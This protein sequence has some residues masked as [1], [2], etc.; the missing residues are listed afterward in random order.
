M[1]GNYDKFSNSNR[2]SMNIAYYFCLC[3]Y[4]CAIVFSQDIPDSYFPSKY[5]QIFHDY[6]YLWQTNSSFKPYQWKSIYKLSIE[7]SNQLVLKWLHEDLKTYETKRIISSKNA[8][9]KLQCDV[10]FGTLLQYSDGEGSKF[11]EGS[12]T[13]YSY[14][15]FRYNNHFKA[16]L[17]PRITTNQ[18]S[19]PHYTGKPRPNKRAGFDTGETDMAGLGYFSNWVQIWFGRGR[20]NWGAFE[21][22]NVA[23][24]EKSAAYDHG[25][26]QFIFNNLRLRYF[27]G[28]LESLENYNHRYITGRG[29]E[30]NNQQNLVLAAHEV[31]I[32]SGVDRPLD[33]AYFNPIST[34]LEIELNEYDNH[35]GDTNGGNAIWQLAADWMPRNGIRFSGNMLAD[36]IALD[37]IERNA[38]KSHAL[39][40]QGRIALSS[41]VKRFA[42]TAFV[43]YTKVGTYTFRH[44][45][46]SNNFISRNIPL[47][48]EIGSDSDQS[49]VG[50]RI[51]TPLRWITTIRIG[52][53][54]KGERTILKD[55]YEPWDQFIRVSFPSGDVE[56]S[57]FVRWETDWVPR[58]NMRINLQSQI[59]KSN[60]RGN[61]NYMIISLD[62]YLPMQFEI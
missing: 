60:L 8:E 39:A 35:P 41:I 1:L 51:I 31:V 21:L 29:I 13:L 53:Q 27:H 58:R 52:N 4:S 12:T 59:C 3:F 47:G 61:Q 38:G 14:L 45:N 9:N 42:Y 10:L 7:D 30:Y 25:T 57:H 6:G 50:V 34:H 16:W 43:E 11:Q 15:Y 49:I 48:T 33:I 32:Y 40:F 36:E 54:R 56:R 44:G 37:K 55:P 2:H 26:L 18:Y 5:L 19:L 28:Y 17:Y 23:L 22:D 62:V 24:S 20:Q 46:G